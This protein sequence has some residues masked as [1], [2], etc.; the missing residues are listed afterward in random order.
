MKFKNSRSGEIVLGTIVFTVVILVFIGWL[1]NIGIRECNSDS[2]C[3]SGYYCGV[4][5]SCH[6]M[7]VVEKQVMHNS[8]VLPAIIIGLAIILAA[9]VIRFGQKK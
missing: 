1:I 4:D 2:Q 7:P 8:L 3:G 5:H 6:K 9:V